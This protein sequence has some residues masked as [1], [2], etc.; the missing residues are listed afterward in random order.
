MKRFKFDWLVCFIV[1]VLAITLGIILIVN[2]Y[3]IGMQILNIVIACILL[4]Y[5]FLFL[6][7]VMQKKSGTIQILT[8][9]EFVIV[10]LIA[11]GLILQ[12]FKV[13]NIAGA[14]RIIG[15]VLWIRAVVELFRAYFYRGKESS[16]K[17]AVWYFCI[18]IVLITLGV[19]MFASPFFT[20]QQ[21]VLA[22][23]ISCF[24]LAILLIVLGIIFVPKKGKK[25]NKKS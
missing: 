12:Q 16:Y 24:I 5:L 11:L 19:W 20:D 7:P 13:F 15:L 1:S 23:S 14:C 21:V 22:L 2:N 8:I 18:I 4:L 6:L 3:K 17:Y 10:A 9:I 25:S